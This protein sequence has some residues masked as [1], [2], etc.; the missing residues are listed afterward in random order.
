MLTARNAL[1]KGVTQVLDEARPALPAGEGPAPLYAV[2]TTNEDGTPGAFFA[3]ANTHQIARHPERIFAD[4]LPKSVQKSVSP[5]TPLEE[6]L[7]LM[8]LEHADA[9]PVLDQSGEF[10]GVVTYR[11]AMTTLLEHGPPRVTVQQAK[12][13]TEGNHALPTQESERIEKLHSSS[14]RLLELLATHRLEENLLQSGIESLAD[15]LQ[16]RYGAIGL[17]DGAGKLKQFVHTGIS[18]DEAARIGHLPQGRGLL[19]IPIPLRLADMSLDARSVGFPPNHPPMKSLLSVSLIHKRHEFG[20]VY[21]SEKLDGSDF[22]EEDEQLLSR[23][24]HVFAM[25]LAYHRTQ[26]ER[27]HRAEVLREISHALSAFTGEMFFRELVLLLSR[28]LGAAYAI[29][30]EVTDASLRTIQTVAV[31]AEG[32]LVDNFTY[33]LAGTPC[34]N[35][36]GKDICFHAQGVQQLFPDDHLLVEMDIDS[37]IGI[38][39]F[40]SAGKPLGILALLDKKPLAD[41]EHAQA[42][43]KICAARAVAELERQHQELVLRDSEERFRAT[44]SQAAVGIAVVAPD[45]RWLRVNQKLCDILGYTEQE[46]LQSTFQDITHP[47]DLA[48][49]LA[50]V[51][52]VLAGEIQTY[53]MEKRYF[54]KDRSIVWIN[55]TVSLVRDE[56]NNPKY[57]ISVV[58]DINERR[59]AEQQ[60]RQLSSAVEQTADSVIITN[61]R[62]VIQYVNPAFEKTTGFSS[63]EAIGKK[64]NIVKSGQHDANFYDRLWKTI[65]EGKPFRDIFTNRRKDGVL[66]FEEKTITPL[67]NSAGLVSQFVSTG[68]DITERVRAEERLNYLAHYDALTGLPNRLLLQDRLN[69]ATSEANRSNR[70]VS[71]MLLDLD[72]FKII[73]D[74]LGHDAGD[75]L[76]VAVADR[77]KVCLRAGD[78]IARIGGD[79][80]T[81]VLANVAHVDDVAR[82]AQKV[83]DLFVPPFRIGGR[84]LFISPSVGISLYP[85]DDKKIENL[86]K[87]ADAAMYH[88]KDLGRNNFQF[89]TAELNVRAAKRL[90]LETALRQAL[91]RNEFLLHYQPQVDL[92]TGR[93]IGMEA[94]VRWQHA[95]MGLVSPMDFIP[96]AEETG[97]IEPIGAWVLHEACAQTK[98]WHRAG[99]RHLQ[100]AVNLSGRQFIQK[101]LLEQIKE[102]LKETGLPPRYLELELTEGVLMHNIEGVLAMLNAL[103]DHDISFS[104]DDFGTGYSSLSYL[105]RFPIHVLK[106]DRSFV[107]DIPGDADDMAISQAIIAMA[108]NLDLKVIA[109]GV[110]TKEQLAFLI[111][112]HCDGMQ[113]YYFSKPLPAEAMTQLLQQDH[114]LTLYKPKKIIKRTRRIAAKKK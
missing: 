93:I 23:F 60:M 73:N 48:S 56:Q 105:K 77:L 27:E 16:T 11:S 4:L 10:M 61:A 22:T 40:D 34:E 87:N 110:E 3:L 25:M 111:E 37:Y 14:L 43:M 12:Q 26:A 29:V 8:A 7:T 19:G 109:E 13:K 76:L 95:E 24:A 78:T 6:L 69:I 5:E 62:G 35:V 51:R 80:F 85:H 92:K 70:L 38:P 104:L 98:A 47:D 114:R 46:L 63:E 94:L 75:A 39:L 79:E 21:L 74:T 30:G 107:R 2:F 1:T 33:D 91:E 54:R 44:F 36:V 88:A 18:A 81:L 89:F 41:P 83:M 65:K 17:V 90:T 31:C 49:D 100:V 113:G 66:Y 108:H 15:I 28:V 20:Q 58:E 42:I 72:R 96:L 101:N 57:F 32:K 50:H 55:L 84:E 112:H 45:G 102:T 99:F 52:Q 59:L 67:R 86:L 64:P 9:I 68:K 103:G 71:V 53:T 97:L 106:I 82:V